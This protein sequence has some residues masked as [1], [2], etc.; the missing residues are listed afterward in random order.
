[1][2]L[3]AERL[4]SKLS[5]QEFGARCLSIEQT[6]GLFA[7]AVSLQSHYSWP[8]A[9]S[10]LKHI[11]RC[12]SPGGTFV[13]GTASDKLDIEQLLQNASREHLM[14]PG[15]RRYCELNR[16][17]AS[18]STGRFLSLDELIQEVRDAGFSVRSARSDFYDH[19]LHCLVLEA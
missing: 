4:L 2:I 1:M 15:W 8:N 14:S 3:L 5:R 11:R 16:E 12:I 9:L 18:S 13:L 10:T 6:D 7:S 19:G 17:F